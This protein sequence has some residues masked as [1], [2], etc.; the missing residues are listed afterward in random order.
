MPS[1][2]QDFQAELLASIKQMRDGQ[3]ARESKVELPTAETTTS[4]GLLQHWL[5]PAAKR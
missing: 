1:E 2:T 4:A 3:V 5:T